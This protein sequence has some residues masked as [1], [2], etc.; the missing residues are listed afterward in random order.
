MLLQRARGKSTEVAGNLFIAGT[1]FLSRRKWIRTPHQQ[2]DLF[3]EGDFRYRV[4]RKWHN[5]AVSGLRVHNSHEMVMDRRNRFYLLTDN[6]DNNVIVFDLAGNVLNTWTLNSPGAHGLTLSVDDD[7]REILWISDAYGSRVVKTS[8]DGAIH[9]TLPDPHRLK[10]YSWKMPYMPTQTA[11]AGNG[12]VYVADGYGSQFVLHFDKRGEFIRRF[13]G[14]GGEEFHL[15]EAHGI[16]VDDRKPGSE[17]LFITSR[18]ESSLKQFQMDGSYTGTISLP[19][20]FP[21][22]PII[23]SDN[24]LIGLCWSGAHLRPNSGFVVVLDRDNR[25]CATL[26][27]QAEFDAAGKLTNLRSDYS[28]FYHVHD[29]C[30]DSA[31][32]LYVCQWNAGR[33]FPLFLEK[34]G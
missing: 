23:H 33:M 12:D 9:Q 20:G 14:R 8:L 26:G 15:D 21:C 34:L 19:G 27:G 13:G 10:L 18:K 32:N 28:T 7:G 4:H 2:T 11:V 30:P 1:R 22:R 3:G 16:A 29:V 5:P 24:I 17:T 6:P 25:V 31:G